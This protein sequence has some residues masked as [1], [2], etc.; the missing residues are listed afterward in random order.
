ML[1]PKPIL[2]GP[3]LVES[4]IEYV[5]PSIFIFI[6]KPFSILCDYQSASS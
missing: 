2:T 1:T 5:V 3:S 6:F 4:I